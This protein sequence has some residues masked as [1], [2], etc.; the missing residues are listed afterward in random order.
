M[1]P[2]SR[3]VFPILRAA[4]VVACATL[5]A[6]SLAYQ[7]RSRILIDVGSNRDDFYVRNFDAAEGDQRQTFRWTKET[8]Q[9]EL[10]GQQLAGPWTL[11]LNLNGYRPDRPAHLALAVNGIPLQELALPGDWQVY[12]M[13]GNGGG[14]QWDG[15]TTLEFRNDTFVPQQEIPGNPDPR[16]LGVGVDWIEWTPTRSPFSFGTDDIWIDPGHLP[17]FPP[18]YV[19]LSWSLALGIL[20]SSVRSLGLPSRPVN[21]FFAFLIV[22]FSLA[23]AFFRI[24]VTSWTFTFLILALVLAVLA[25]SLKFFVPRLAA[26]FSIQMD[27]SSVTVLCAI[28]L[29]SVGLKWGGV[30][31]PQFKSSDLAFHSHRLEFVANGNFFFTSEL[32]DAARR[33]VPY[34][35]ALYIFLTPLTPWV[36]QH[37]N[38][39]LIAN[40][41][42]DAIGILA[43]YFGARLALEHAAPRDRQFAL[44]AAFLFAF[45]PV[46]FWIYSWGNHTNIFGEMAATILFCVLLTQPLTRPRNFLVALFFLVLASTAHLGIFLSLFTFFPVL[47][48]LQLF[49]P[50]GQ[51]GR[52]VGALLLLTA[53][54]IVLE[55][56]LYYG[57]FAGDLLAQTQQFIFDFGAG[58]AGT[59]GGV[60]L[61]RIVN[62]AR[63]TAE[64]VGW[65]L[66]LTGLVGIPLAWKHF[67][68]R[69]GSVWLAW[70]VVGLVFGLV[71]IG[72][73][74]STRYTLWAAPALAL[75]GG[76]ALVWLV[77]KSRVAH[78]AAYALCAFALAQTLWLWVDRVMNAYQ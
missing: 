62:V 56:L 26:R 1:L 19:V 42:A 17:I 12:E 63:Y 31:Y 37:E 66:L 5:L 55:G 23:F 71:T 49:R 18:L 51:R 46:T 36:T 2:A 7:I 78:Y 24:Y 39:L 73:T 50:G 53:T 69:A 38:L 43:L 60:T 72:S 57:E 22:A 32:P 3:P 68:W 75:S 61:E 47:L 45:N 35:P 74:F 21:L 58:R 25:L 11:R 59:E 44:F 15:T 14:N 6:L 16:T 65:V 4:L 70:L 33:V 28:V 13:T 10:I 77:E 40:V 8:A 54:G 76:L 41:I 9:V 48:A 52:E 27:A 67:S 34:P 29:A 30:W 20:Y 64:Q